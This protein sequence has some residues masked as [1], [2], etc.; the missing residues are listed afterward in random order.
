VEFLN[1]HKHNLKASK[2]IKMDAF[3][4]NAIHLQNREP[5]LIFE[6]RRP[7]ESLTD[8]ALKYRVANYRNETSS[9]F[10][11]AIYDIQEVLNE[12]EI[13]IKSESVPLNKWVVNF[14]KWID[15]KNYNI[16]SYFFD[17]ILQSKL[18][19]ANG[20]LF[21]LPI[22][23]GL[24]FYASESEF[25][26][27]D[28]KKVSVDL[29]HFDC[30]KIESHT[31]NEILINGGK[32]AYN[33]KDGLKEKDFYY[34][35]VKNDLYLIVPSADG[36][37]T[38]PYYKYP[39][40]SMPIVSLGKILANKKDL[41]YFVSEFFGSLQ[42]ADKYI[43][44]DSDL[45]VINSRSHPIKFVFKQNCNMSGCGYS[46]QFKRFGYLGMSG[47]FEQCTKCGGTGE[48]NA[49][50][51]PFTTIKIEKKEGMNDDDISV[52][53][54]IGFASPPVDILNYHK[55]TANE[56][57]MKLANSLCVNG[58]QNITNQSAEAKSYDLGQKV[59]Q[60]SNICEDLI[61]IVN[62]SLF[63]VGCI[64]DNKSTSD[65]EVIKPF[66]WDVKSNNDLLS[67]LY[68]AK[69]NNA[70]YFVLMG[71]IKKYLEK[72]YKTNKFKNEIVKTL[73]SKDKLLPYGI[74][75]LGGARAV[76]GTDIEQTDIIKHNFAEIIVEEI[77]NEKMLNDSLDF[78]I[79]FD[80]KLQEYL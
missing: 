47:E 69:V 67:E 73:I 37:K 44:I 42:I 56:L 32:W 49:D 55:E 79:E 36:E 48:I 60:I 65:V 2:D 50:T 19:D 40:L 10:L 53:N 46:P 31:E 54:P 1:T 75:D 52:R 70:P 43:G 72:K 62:Q 38:I 63:Y 28:N 5:S 34:K 74:N 21:N 45:T 17:Y 3:F 80:K 66:K 64:L 14:N 59:T 15:F 68:D 7:Y 12:S 23:D 6:E 78:S 29:L 24:K 76:F 20:V 41:K 9:L 27:L 22:I 16:Y 77:A 58:E 57:Y 25:L 61:R 39:T 4:R 26:P 13:S 51:S 33:D 35:V 11:K 30:T 71:I 18:V 8:H